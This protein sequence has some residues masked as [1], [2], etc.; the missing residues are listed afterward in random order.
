MI[1]ETRVDE[2]KLAECCLAFEQSRIPVTSK[3]ALVSACVDALA[4]VLK[5][6]GATVAVEDKAT[7]ETIISRVLKPRVF[8][9]TTLNIT[10]LRQSVLEAASRI[11]PN[12]NN[13]ER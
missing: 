12:P 3:S 2:C 7:A 9:T 8:D 11:T 4:D 1:I 6:N 5:K 13:H 10:A